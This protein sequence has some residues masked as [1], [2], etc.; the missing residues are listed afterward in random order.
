M[1]GICLQIF[2]WDAK[3]VLFLEIGSGTDFF[4]G[5]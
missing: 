4:G 2:D 1:S 3:V 5:G